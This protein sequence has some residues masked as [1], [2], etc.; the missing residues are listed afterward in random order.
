MTFKCAD[1][2]AC[3]ASVRGAVSMGWAQQLRHNEEEEWDV[4]MQKR[5]SNMLRHASQALLSK[6]SWATEIFQDS[7][8]DS[9]ARITSKT[10]AASSTDAAFYGYDDEAEAAWRQR[11]N[12]AREYSRTV[13]I[14]HPLFTPCL[15]S[16]KH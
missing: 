9:E 1:L 11:P 15:F 8:A 5:L 13:E 3:M 7:T 4:V 2:R 6:R 12:H 10:P 14:L 16:M